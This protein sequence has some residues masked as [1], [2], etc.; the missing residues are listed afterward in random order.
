MG[1]PAGKGEASAL[2][3]LAQAAQA[4]ADLAGRAAGTPLETAA[5]AAYALVLDA[6]AGVADFTPGDGCAG[7]V[8]VALAFLGSAIMQGRAVL[9]SRERAADALAAARERGREEGPGPRPGTGGIGP[10][11]SLVVMRSA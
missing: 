2:A 7:D 6:A 5:L 1:T 9:A 11:L 3:A 10:A 8:A 4:V